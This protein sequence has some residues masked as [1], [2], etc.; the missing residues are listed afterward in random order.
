VSYGGSSLLTNFLA[1]ALLISVSQHR[2]Y[3]L[4]TKPFEFGEEAKEKAHLAEYKDALAS[5]ADPAKRPAT[6]PALTVHDDA[7]V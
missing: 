1:V 3:L 6:Q 4:A 2:P 7:K 5:P